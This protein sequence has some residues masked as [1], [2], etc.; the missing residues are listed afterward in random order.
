MFE[1]V[2]WNVR[3]ICESCRKFSKIFEWTKTKFGNRDPQKRK[4]KETKI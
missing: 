4:K 2:M 1:K 3:K